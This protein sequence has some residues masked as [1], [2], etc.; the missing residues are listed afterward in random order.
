MLRI[1][2][3]TLQLTSIC[4]LH[5]ATKRLSTLIKQIL[6]F[7]HKSMGLLPPLQLKKKVFLHLPPY[8]ILSLEPVK[9]YNISLYPYYV[10]L[11]R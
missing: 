3:P 9:V 11:K 5:H 2:A 8:M 10:P 1:K 4:I 6:Y 7:H